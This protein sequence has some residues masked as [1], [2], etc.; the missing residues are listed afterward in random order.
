MA[1]LFGSW[2]WGLRFTPILGI[3]AVILLLVINDP[4]R[5]ESE[6]VNLSTTSWWDDIKYLCTKLE[7]TAFIND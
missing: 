6:G 2:H 1:A 5:G 4:P 3:I 7:S